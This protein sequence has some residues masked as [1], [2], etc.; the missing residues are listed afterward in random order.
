MY[1]PGGGSLS[2]HAALD[3][4]HGYYRWHAHFYDATRWAFLFG[5]TALI[6]SAAERLRPRRILEVGCGTGR[7]LVELARYFPHAQIVGLDLSPDMLSKARKKT[8]IY[9]PRVTLLEGVYSF[10]VSCGDPFDL[11]VFSY[12]LSMI[13]PGF[14][15][16]LRLCDQDLSSR[17]HLALVDFHDTRFGWFRRWMGLN[18]VRMDGQILAA[19][20]EAKLNLDPCIVGPA[21]GGLW[22]WFTCLATKHTEG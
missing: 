19:L 22:R 5:R 2:G 16:V 18:H 11:I 4:L 1:R 8:Q 21:Y 7:N 20:E 9:G 17:G 13:N 14:A 15:E 10:P 12:C 6:R 3:S